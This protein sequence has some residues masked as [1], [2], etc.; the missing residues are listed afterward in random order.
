MK[1]LVN[2]DDLQYVVYGID[3]YLHLRRNLAAF[4]DGR[5]AVAYLKDKQSNGNDVETFYIENRDAKEE[6]D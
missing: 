2:A 1:K 3:K 6:D 5:E 4:N